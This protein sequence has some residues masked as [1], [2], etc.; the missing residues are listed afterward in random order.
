MSARGTSNTNARGNVASRRA[1]R[2]WLI[3]REGWGSGFGW[4]LCVFC[5]CELRMDN[6]TV[7]RII[8]GIL[9]GTYERGNIRPACLRCNAIEGSR[10]RDLL[11]GGA[12]FFGRGFPATPIRHL[13]P[14]RGIRPGQAVTIRRLLLDGRLNQTRI[15]LEAGCSPVIVRKL[16]PRI[17][18]HD[19]GITEEDA[20]EWASESGER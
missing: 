10:L 12:D 2:V 6:I 5:G 18:T 11:R 1:R 7:D 13:V 8:P 4:T 9:G 16:R 3:S 17:E 20:H 15:A 19:S 14:R